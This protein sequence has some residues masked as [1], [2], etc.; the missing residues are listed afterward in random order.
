MN[1]LRLNA[2]FAPEITAGT[3]LM[4]DLYEAF[5]KNNIKCICITPQPTRGVSQSEHKHY[6]KYEEYY[7]GYV[8]V[9]RFPM[10]NEKKNPL[11]RALRYG[12]C[13]LIEYGKGIH[14]DDI[15][16]VFSSSTPPTQGMI[17]AMIA[18]KL[19]KK[20]KKKVP[21]VYNLQDV[22]P[23]S[24]VNSGMTYKGSFIW[25]IGRKIETYIYSN[26]DKIIVISNA[27]KKNLL[28][29]GV[30]KEKIEVV[31]NWID[32][33][34]V[35]CVPREQ[36]TLIEEY[37][38]DSQKF[39]VT[40]AGNFGAAQGADIILKVAEKLKEEKDIQF[41]IFGGGLEFNAAVEYVEEHHL[42]NIIIKPLLPQNRISE[43]YSLGDVALITCKPG[44]GKSGL[45]SKTWSIMA[46]NTRIVASFDTDSDLA[47]VI[48]TADAGRCV[49]PGTADALYQ[50]ISAEYMK[51]KKD[52]VKCCSTRDYVKRNASKDVCVTDYINILK[53]C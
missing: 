34:T 16:V 9:H 5:S 43:I 23:D 19:S 30:P 25:K 37:N 21:F 17:S 4:N 11:L 27:M 2:Y 15:D 8:H 26:A 3:H 35:K 24:M 18:K 10:F 47:E 52:N 46:C 39:I 44:T 42:T 33:D 28:E 53:G 22:F 45:P 41:V 32:L 13:S 29:K 40:Y 51:W 48:K 49:D 31:S 38:I 36:N 6:K 50:G 14:M 12:A 20:Y 7:D 1:I